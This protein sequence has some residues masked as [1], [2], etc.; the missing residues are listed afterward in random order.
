MSDGV[1]E[2]LDAIK[3]VLYRNIEIKRE[4]INKPTIRSNRFVVFMVYR[5]TQK[6]NS[7]DIASREL[8][9]NKHVKISKLYPKNVRLK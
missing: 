4:M 5:R 2:C 1:A 8:V 7:L 9:I 3:C 6:N